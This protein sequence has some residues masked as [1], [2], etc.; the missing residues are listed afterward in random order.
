MTTV[1]FRVLT[2]QIRHWIHRRST[3]KQHPTTETFQA[4][5]IK[6]SALDT[7]TA[8]QMTCI[9]KFILAAISEFLLHFSG[10]NITIKL[11]S[12]GF[13]QTLHAVSGQISM[14]FRIA[15]GQQNSMPVCDVFIQG[16]TGRKGISFKQS[17]AGQYR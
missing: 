11:E 8:Y 10:G 17:P 15:A 2:S 6:I 12:A 7:Q 16:L 1:H 13:R 5:Q 14:F 3:I 9:I 4:G